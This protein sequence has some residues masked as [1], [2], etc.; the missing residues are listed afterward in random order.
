MK[1]TAEASP[2]CKNTQVSDHHPPSL[3]FFFSPSIRSALFVT[4]ST[5]LF[6]FLFPLSSPYLIPLDLLPFLITV[7]PFL[8][9]SGLFGLTPNTHTYNALLHS[10][11]SAPEVLYCTMLRLPSSQP[12][13]PP[14]SLPSHCCNTQQHTNN[15]TPLVLCGI[16][17]LLDM[18]RLCYTCLH[19]FGDGILLTV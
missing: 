1:A 19:S 10:I 3:I 11:A 14:S 15:F 12:S 4:P 18:I 7:F 16:H 8:P 5:L 17:Q 6:F 2:S 13:S 9:S